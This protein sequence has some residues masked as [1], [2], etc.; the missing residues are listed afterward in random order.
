MQKPL[1][2]YQENMEK[3]KTLEDTQTIK[4]TQRIIQ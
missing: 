3:K 1:N 2:E 4:W